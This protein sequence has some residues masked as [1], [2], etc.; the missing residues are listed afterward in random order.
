MLNVPGAGWAPAEPRDGVARP[1]T[2]R[3]AQR[4]DASWVAPWRCSGLVA[5]RTN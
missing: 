2:D 3:A 5:A 4:A 1:L